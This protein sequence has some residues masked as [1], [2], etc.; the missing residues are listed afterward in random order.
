MRERL[1]NRQQPPYVDWAEQWGEWIIV[2]DGTGYRHFFD[3]KAE[4]EEYLR[5]SCIHGQDAYIWRSLDK[6]FKGHKHNYECAPHWQRGKHGNT[7]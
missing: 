5:L 1:T 7:N 3:C 6:W 2:I 4:A